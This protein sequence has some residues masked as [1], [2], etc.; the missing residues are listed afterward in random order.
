MLREKTGATPGISQKTEKE[1]ETQKTNS[2]PFAKPIRRPMQL[3]ILAHLKCSVCG[4]N[5]NT[6]MDD[7]E[8]TAYMREHPGIDLS[9]VTD[10]DLGEVLCDGC[11]DYMDDETEAQAQDDPWSVYYNPDEDERVSDEEELAEIHA[12]DAAIDRAWEKH[13][14]DLAEKGATEKCV[15]EKQTSTNN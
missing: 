9:K 10:I 2:I 8:I 3:R 13:Y 12:E 15:S 14:R 1:T 5:V 6:I 11:E 7:M 4:D